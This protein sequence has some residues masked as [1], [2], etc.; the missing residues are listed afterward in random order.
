MIVSTGVL[1]FTFIMRYVIKIRVKSQVLK[2]RHQRIIMIELIFT[3]AR[4]YNRRNIDR[5]QCR[6][7][8]GTV[9]CLDYSEVLIGEEEIVSSYKRGS[10]AH[11][12]RET[13]CFPLPPGIFS[14]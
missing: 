9:K 3:I 7:D 5:V 6:E 11:L 12:Q 13:K 4:Y 8:N 2:Y 1:G 10:R 14:A